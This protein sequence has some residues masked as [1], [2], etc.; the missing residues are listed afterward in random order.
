MKKVPLLVTSSLTGVLT[1]AAIAVPAYAW[2]PEGKIT[3]SVQNQTTGS[4]MSD[5]NTIDTAVS[6]TTG[7]ILLYSVTLQN[8]GATDGNGYNDMAF[9]KI[10]D[11]LPTGLVFADDTQKRTINE[12]LANLKPGA[13]V[14]KTY[15]VKVTS[16]KNGDVI[17]NEAC[18]D[19]N[20]TVKDHPLHAC[21]KAVIKVK[22]TPPVTPPEQP[23]VTPPTTPPVE[24]PE[25]LPDTGSTALTALMFVSVTAAIGYAVNTLRLKFRA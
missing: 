12:D 23:P 6:A 18:Y 9:V 3:K 16:T 17:T 10:S 21:D 5:A 11:T 25:T 4:L 22:V 8:V 1:A 20:S 24:T 19:A 7:D 2:H 14:T 13:S 15:K